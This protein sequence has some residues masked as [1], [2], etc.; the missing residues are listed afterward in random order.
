VSTRILHVSDLH[1]GARNGLDEPGLERAIAE[2]VERIDPT[3]VICSGDLTHRGHRDQQEAAASY[4]RGLGPPLFVVPGN[5]DI[6]LLPPARFTHTWREFERQWPETQPVHSSPALQVVGLNSVRPWRHQSG[7]V[8]TAQLDAAA[9][10]LDEAEP[11]ALRVVVL[12][13][14][15][16][17]APWRSRKKPVAR[18][19][20]VLAQLVGSGAEL[21]LSGHVHQGTVGERHE[22]QIVGGDAH[23]VVVATAP[24]LGRPRP[25]RL[26]EARGV[27]VYVADERQI[28]VET[29]I[30]GGERWGLTALRTFPRGTKPLEAIQEGAA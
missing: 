25:N 15:M 29:Y 18:R 22:F 3:L 19:G 11:G 10:R 21:I 2:L 16:V 30:W 20:A 14:Q 26:H 8:T 28:R 6:P 12:H 4:L 13:H 27:F 5:H 1:F 23:S 9:Q 17:G 7:K 24:G